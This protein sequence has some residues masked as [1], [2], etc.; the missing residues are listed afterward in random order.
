[1]QR[2]KPPQRA[3]QTKRVRHHAKQFLRATAKQTVFVCEPIAGPVAQPFA[4]VAIGFYFNKFKLVKGDQKM[5]R[6]KIAIGLRVPVRVHHALKQKAQEI[7]V[8][9]NDL[10][11][12]LI[13]IGFN[14]WER[15]N[16]AEQSRVCA[17]KQ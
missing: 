8:S 11:L 6:E 9:Q 15:F 17:R 7:G 5:T 10:I 3:A 2:D 12:T 13:E 14:A 1:M 16:L 4:E